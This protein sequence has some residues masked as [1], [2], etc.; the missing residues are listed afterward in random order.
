[1]CIEKK[2]YQ[3]LGGF[4]ETLAR[5][6]FDGKRKTQSFYSASGNFIS[7]AGAYSAPFTLMILLPTKKGRENW[8][9]YFRLR[10]AQYATMPTTAI[11]TTAMIMATSAVMSG[12]AVGS[13]G[14]IGPEGAAAGPTAR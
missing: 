3:N 11:T 7:R 9:V 8:M 13:S 5:A 6:S 1:M 2:G 12:A 14:C 4:A 10:S